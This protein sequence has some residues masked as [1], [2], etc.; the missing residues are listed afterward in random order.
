MNIWNKVF[1]GVIIATAVAVLALAAVEFHI[2]STGQ[3]HIV[4][5]EQR[6]EETDARI[7]RIINGT[8][9]EPSFEELRGQLRGQENER[10]RAWFG[11][12]ISN[13]VVETFPPALTQVTALITVTGPLV[14]SETGAETE[15]VF[16]E[17][18]RGIVYAFE[19]S[20][21]GDVGV[22]L[23]RF[24]VNTEPTP[25]PFRDNDG[26]QKT[27]YR[28]T[29][30]SA[31][32]IC[33]KEID[34]IF[35]AGN[36]RWAIFQEPP[37][38]RIAGIFDQLTEEERQMLPEEFL[39]RFQPRPMRELTDEER[40]GVDS[41]VIVVWEQLRGAIDDPE[42]EAAQDYALMLDWLYQR[43]STLLRE[44]EDAELDIATF[45][46]AEENTR[47]EN[48]KLEADGDLEEKRAEAMNVQREA[49]RA[50]LAQYQEEV[51]RITLLIE[52]LQTLN[53]AYVAKIAE[54]H[55]TAIEKM[56]GQVATPAQT[57]DEAEQQ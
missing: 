16:P 23:G 29:L 24:N 8:T 35:E 47:T 20:A 18:L 7:D 56:E 51:N 3:R 1:L 17:L 11:N 21:E 43:R 41:N 14:P 48:E 15:V 25:M 2:R 45:R 42:A 49:V 39:E 34:Q 5:L 50:M 22:F 55:A 57:E 40:E 26:N 19:E 31:D 6:V 32:P 52:K 10:G 53:A 37:L 9:T 27:G 4:S 30:V 46:M 36:S 28:V 33:D 38:D 54:H 44:I 13:L 12:I